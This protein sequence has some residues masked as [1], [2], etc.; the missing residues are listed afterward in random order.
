MSREQPGR[1]PDQP[2]R[3]ARKILGS[4]AEGPADFW[5][6]GG[7][8][9]R[10]PAGLVIFLR[11]TGPQARLDFWN[12]RPPARLM[13]FEGKPHNYTHTHFGTN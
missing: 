7:K 11:Q 4:R 3:K 1:K 2:G 9:G 10:R 12:Q 8:P 13:R 5:A 6:F